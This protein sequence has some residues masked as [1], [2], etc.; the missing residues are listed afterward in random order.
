MMNIVMFKCIDVKMFLSLSTIR[1]MQIKSIVEM[2]SPDLRRRHKSYLCSV[3][4]RGVVM[5]SG[6]QHRSKEAPQSDERRLG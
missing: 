3:E 2:E 5:G 4:V 6:R 1:V